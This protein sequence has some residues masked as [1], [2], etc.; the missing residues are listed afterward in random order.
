LG[1]FG[2]L[3]ISKFGDWELGNWE[4]RGDNFIDTT[5][6]WESGL[7]VPLKWAYGGGKL[8]VKKE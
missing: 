5:Q 4:L 3:K 6:K 7:W 2:S 1:T 8:E